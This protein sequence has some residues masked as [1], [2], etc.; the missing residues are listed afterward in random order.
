MKEIEL[1]ETQQSISTG[2]ID[3][4]YMI[5]PDIVRNAASIL[6]GTIQSNLAH[7]TP[8]S[9]LTNIVSITPVTMKNAW[10][11]F[12]KHNAEAKRERSESA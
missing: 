11:F 12:W 10:R 4:P 9:L 3:D 7:V 6:Y 5:D 1:I 8:V 2:P